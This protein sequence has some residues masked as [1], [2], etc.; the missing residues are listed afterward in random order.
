MNCST[1]VGIAT[2]V[3]DATKV[4]KS[5]THPYPYLER[6]EMKIP[7]LRKGDRV[8]VIWEDIISDSSWVDDEKAAK[9]KTCTCH[10]VGYYINRSK[11]LFRLSHCYNAD[12]QRSVDVIPRGCITA[13][14]KLERVR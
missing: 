6:Q 1:P 12:K 9:A 8:E 3:W 5:A 11:W 10:T 4:P 13:V 14:N 7:R 2:P